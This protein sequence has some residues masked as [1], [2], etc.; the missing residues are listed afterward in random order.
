MKEQGILDHEYRYFGIDSPRGHRWYNF[1]PQ[2][3]LEYAMEGTYGGWQPGDNTSRDYVPGEVAVV[4]NDGTIE[5]CNPRDIERPIFEITG[6]SWDD[7]QH[8]LMMGQVYE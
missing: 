3:F 6:I 8:F 4:T 2:T 7:F 1:D 5:S